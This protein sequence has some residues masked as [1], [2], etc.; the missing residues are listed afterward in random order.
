MLTQVYLAIN[1]SWNTK[2]PVI[3]D[4]ELSSA[5]SHVQF[6]IDRLNINDGGAVLVFKQETAMIFTAARFKNNDRLSRAGDNSPLMK[7]GEQG[8]AV[9]IVQQALTDLK[10]YKFPGSTDTLG[11]LD[12][13]FGNETKSNVW[14]F[15][16]DES[17]EDKDGIVGGQ[18]LAKLDKLLVITPTPP[19]PTIKPKPPK[20]VSSIEMDRFTKM[21]VA[22]SKRLFPA[23][24]DPF[25]HVDENYV[26]ARGAAAVRIS[27]MAQFRLQS[28]AGRNDIEDRWNKGRETWWFGLYSAR[29]FR[30]VQR[31]FV[32]IHSILANERLKLDCELKFKSYGS[33]LPGI[34]HIKL[35]ALWRAPGQSSLGEDEEERVQTFIHEAAH[36]TGRSN[37]AEA[38]GK[39]GK[40]LSHQLAGNGMK[41]T[42]HADCYGYYA[43]DIALTRP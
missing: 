24:I 7:M 12:G 22:S 16:S 17:L 14:Q 29:K 39:Y 5:I 42:R 4:D 35:G 21:D 8:A 26:R 31:T 20:P 41:A 23:K 13:I 18:T 40:I 10:K 3:F 38:K 30:K 1:R 15:Q 19:K 9:V 43:L 25:M 11:N 33:A 34:R 37:L 36:I 27:R 28:L 2:Q 32:H 6:A